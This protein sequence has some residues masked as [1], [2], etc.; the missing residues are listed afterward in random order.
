MSWLLALVPL[1]ISVRTG[2]TAR[3]RE[4]GK[5]DCADNNALRFVQNM[6][7]TDIYFHP[8]LELLER[9]RHLSRPIASSKGGQRGKCETSGPNL[10]RCVRGNFMCNSPLRLTLASCD[11]WYIYLSTRSNV[12]ACIDNSCYWKFVSREIR[13]SQFRL[14]L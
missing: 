6:P 9:R 7:V 14:V 1:V 11:T 8:Y 10:E 2:E 4:N 5:R 12:M 3:N 13:G